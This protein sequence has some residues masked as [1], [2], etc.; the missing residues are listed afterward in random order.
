MPIGIVR[1]FEPPTFFSF[2]PADGYSSKDVIFT[3]MDLGVTFDDRIKREFIGYNFNVK[4]SNETECE[5]YGC[6]FRKFA[7][8]KI[9]TY[10]CLKVFDPSKGN[11]W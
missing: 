10:L 4:T 2:V 5:C 1:L 9:K 6:L 8:L 3:W 7:T 11:Y